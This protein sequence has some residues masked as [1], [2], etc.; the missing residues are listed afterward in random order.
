MGLEGLELPRRENVTANTNEIEKLRLANLLTH[1][2]FGIDHNLQYLNIRE[3]SL[4][5]P[6]AQF[7]DFSRAL[8]R[9]TA[10]SSAIEEIVEG[11]PVDVTFPDGF[12]FEGWSSYLS[13]SLSA[14]GVNVLENGWRDSNETRSFSPSAATFTNSQPLRELY[15]HRI[16]KMPR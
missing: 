1:K 14:M 12:P 11:S 15:Q 3:Q 16:S 6:Y 10:I 5:K 4:S 9:D 13:S 2:R 8:L 7:M